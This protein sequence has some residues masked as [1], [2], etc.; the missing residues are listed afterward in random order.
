M[1]TKGE[2]HWSKEDRAKAILECVTIGDANTCKKYSINPQTLRRWHRELKSGS[3]NELVASVRNKKAL[4]DK[5]WA[6]KIPEALSACLDFITRAARSADIN[7][8]EVIHAVAGAMKMI[9]ETD[10]TYKT[11]DA[12]ISGQAS[13]NGQAPGPLPAGVTPIR[14]AV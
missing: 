14:K 2:R 4:L 13:G 3:D 8:A 11:I 7:D 10:G 9:A 6:T 5:A 12:R 1:A